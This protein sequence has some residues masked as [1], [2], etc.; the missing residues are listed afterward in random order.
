MCEEWFTC[1]EMCIRDRSDP[2]YSRSLFTAIREESERRYNRLKQMKFRNIVEHNDEMR[3]QG[4]E[5]E[6]I[7]RIIFLVDEFQV[8][9]TKADSKTIE[10]VNTDIT[11]LSKVARAA[12]VHVI[13]CSQ[14]M[15]GTISSDILNMFTLRICLRCEPEVSLQILGTPYACLLYTSTCLSVN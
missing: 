7:P 8:I 6:I 13:F 3:K 11:I 9:Y 15:K 2:D 14:S 5:D 10:S 12:V 4:R 1:G